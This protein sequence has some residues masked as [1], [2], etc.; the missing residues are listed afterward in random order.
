MYHFT[1]LPEISEWSSSFTSFPVFDGA[2]IFILMILI[3]VWWCLTVVII[4]IPCWLMMLSL[5]S[6]GFCN[7]H[8]RFG[9][10][11]FTSFAHFSHWLIIFYCWIWEL[12]I[13]ARRK[14]FVGYVLRKYFLPV[15]SLLILFTWV[16]AEQRFFTFWSGPI[17]WFFIL[18]IV[19]LVSSLKTLCLILNCK[20][21]VLLFKSFIVLCFI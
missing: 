14:S 15:C 19:F 7:L 8:T 10:N 4:C 21:F 12:F 6:C 9:E 17:C 3:G 11:I 20:D 5:Y 1:F 18:Q 2:A 16:F 13:Y